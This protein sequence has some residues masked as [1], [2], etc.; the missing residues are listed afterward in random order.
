MTM[1][2]LSLLC[3]GHSGTAAAAGLA[4]GAEGVAVDD[5]EVEAVVGV[6]E[7]LGAAAGPPPGAWAKS[8]AATGSMTTISSP[9]CLAR[10]REDEPKLRESLSPDNA[11]SS[12]FV[13]GWRARDAFQSAIWGGELGRY[14]TLGVFLILAR[15]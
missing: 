10:L 5:A 4:P 13:P 6:V 15:A 2:W 11:S 12:A 1:V 7:E 8:R 14:A 3:R 9:F